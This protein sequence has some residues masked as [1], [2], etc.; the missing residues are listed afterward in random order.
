MISSVSRG[1]FKNEL[2]WH[3]VHRC[4]SASKIL[5]SVLSLSNSSQIGMY[6]FSIENEVHAQIIVVDVTISELIEAEL[7]TAFGLR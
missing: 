6:D 1:R 3:A 4:N 7:E 2:R 5:G